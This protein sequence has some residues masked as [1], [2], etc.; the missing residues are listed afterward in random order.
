[1]ES[2]FCQTQKLVHP[3]PCPCCRHFIT[4]EEAIPV[5]GPAAAYEYFAVPLNLGKLMAVRNKSGR[6]VSSLESAA[7]LYFELK[8]LCCIEKLSSN[9]L[10]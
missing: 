3:P 10:S 8:H 4:N 1:M 2:A 5:D 9:K 7:Q 6:S